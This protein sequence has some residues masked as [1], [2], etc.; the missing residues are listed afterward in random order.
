M[1]ED[2]MK[3]PRHARTLLR[4]T[5]ALLLFIHGAYR[6]LV[7]GVPDFGG[8][9]ASKGFPFGVALAGAITAFELAGGTLLAWGRLVRPV[10][11]GFM[12]NLLAGILLVHGREGWFVVGGGR[13][14]VEYS[15]LLIACLAS[16]CLGEAQ[17]AAPQ[18]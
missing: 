4:V 10:A 14:G 5:V 7:H 13:N 9:L 17:A 1:P 2:S 18:G 12:A 11:C 15:V 6:L 3:D 16:L 8:F